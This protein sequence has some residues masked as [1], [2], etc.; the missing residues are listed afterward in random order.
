VLNAAL[1]PP[2][3][4]CGLDCMQDRHRDG[5]AAA[6]QAA[7]SDAPITLPG[8]PADVDRSRTAYGGEP[9][10]DD[11][12]AFVTDPVRFVADTVHHYFQPVRWFEAGEV[13]VT[14]AVNDFD[15]PIPTALQ[16]EMIGRLAHAPQVVQL[17]SGHLPAITHPELLAAV[18]NETARS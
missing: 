18:I 14:Y 16:W 9:L 11:D 1:V 3:G 6:V 7:P 17:P 5:L 4:G 15:R 8:P 2:E 13:P 12:V 10:G